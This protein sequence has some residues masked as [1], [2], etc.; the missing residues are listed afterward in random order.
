MRNLLLIIALYLTTPVFSN[1][2][3]E[4]NLIRYDKAVL[5]DTAKREEILR[6]VICRKIINKP[7]GKLLEKIN[8]DY[9]YIHFVEMKP[10]FLSFVSIKYGEGLWLDIYV[11]KYEYTKQLLSEKEYDSRDSF[12]NL[13]NLLNEKI[14]K[15]RLRKQGKVLKELPKNPQL[16]NW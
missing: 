14:G 13:N 1:R 8:L 15:I 3:E 4:N 16:P 9:S 7:I 10:Y 12:W 6:K 2:Q 5:N 11:K